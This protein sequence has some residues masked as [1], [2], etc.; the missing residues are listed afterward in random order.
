MGDH[1]TAESVHPAEERFQRVNIHVESPGVVAHIL[2]NHFVAQC[3]IIPSVHII[4]VCL[5]TV[6][7]IVG[8][9]E[10]GTI[11][12]IKGQQDVSQIRIIQAA[13]PSGCVR[14]CGMILKIFSREPTMW[15]PLST[16]RYSI[17]TV[18]ANN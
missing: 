6:G 15:T 4:H 5:F 1:I 11:V 12:L 9:T 14:F 8:C 13:I 17:L 7:D 10:K 3:F 2:E 18:R 16:I